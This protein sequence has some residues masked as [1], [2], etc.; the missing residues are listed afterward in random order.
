MLHLQVYWTCSCGNF[1]KV[2]QDWISSFPLLTCCLSPGNRPSIHDN[3][4]CNPMKYIP[5]N[6]SLLRNWQQFFHVLHL[7]LFLSIIV[8][9]QGILS[10][11]ISVILILILLFF[12]YPFLLHQ[13]RLPTLFYSQENLEYQQSFGGAVMHSSPYFDDIQCSSLLSCF[14]LLAYPKIFCAI[15]IIPLKN[16]MAV[17]YFYHF[18]GNG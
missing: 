9:V 5:D 1:M 14:F 2:C 3:L 8:G 15:R 12:F 17:Q 6:L 13:Y 11:I 10:S 4:P 7:C 18:W 16:I